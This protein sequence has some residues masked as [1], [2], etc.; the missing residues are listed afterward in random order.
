VLDGCEKVIF[1]A[2]I[3]PIAPLHDFAGFRFAFVF[4]KQ[5]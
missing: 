2:R 3:D 1:V 4:V 5:I